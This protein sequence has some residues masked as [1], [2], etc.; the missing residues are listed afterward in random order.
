MGGG[1]GG[2]YYYFFFDG[3]VSLFADVYLNPELGLFDDDLILGR[4]KAL[5]KLF[6]SLAVSPR[7]G[8]RDVVFIVNR[9]L[10]LRVNLLTLIYVFIGV[11]FRF[12]GGPS[13]RCLNHQLADFFTKVS[14]ETP[15]LRSLNS[16]DDD[17]DDDDELIPL[18]IPKQDSSY[19]S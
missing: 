16:H 3:R 11:A 18:F 5:K 7:G 17:D 10:F 9:S 13:G 15:Q 4:Q 14:T 19:T 12:V 2:K 1:R 6:L 8:G